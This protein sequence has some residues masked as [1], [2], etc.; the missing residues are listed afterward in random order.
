[1][2]CNIDPPILLAS[3]TDMSPAC[4]FVLRFDCFLLS[5]TFSVDIRCHVLDISIVYHDIFCAP[6]WNFQVDFYHNILVQRLLNQKFIPYAKQCLLP[7][8][9]SVYIKDLKRSENSSHF[10]FL[11][12]KYSRYFCNYYD[13]S[14]CTNWKRNNIFRLTNVLGKEF[15]T[16]KEYQ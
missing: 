3:T 10:S 15:S 16:A 2:P 8:F 11:S 1:M 14:L 6:T 7:L 4:P 12:S 13:E 9:R 5:F